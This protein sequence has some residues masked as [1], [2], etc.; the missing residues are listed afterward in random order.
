MWNVLLAAGLATGLA[1]AP[2]AAHPA[3]HYAGRCQFATVDDGS[4]TDEGHWRGEA[5]VVVVATA[6]D[7]V[8][9]APLVAISVECRL[10]VDGVFQQTFA[11]AAGTGVA[12]AL[13]L[14]FTFSAAY[15]ARVTVCDVVT[16]GGERHEVCSTGEDPEPTWPPDLPPELDRLERLL[17]CA[18]DW[19]CSLLDELTCDVP[20]TDVPGVVEFREDGDIYVAGEWFWDC[21][22]YGT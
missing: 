17:A 20:G 8:T 2:V 9:P 19:S 18:G 4:G 15:E 7:G 13:D 6:A 1:A 5:S 21:P 22:P 3:Y 12:A 14:Q 10:Y 16:V 11:S